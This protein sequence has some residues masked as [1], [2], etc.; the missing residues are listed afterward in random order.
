MQYSKTCI[1][2][3]DTCVDKNNAKNIL[4]NDSI[5]NIFKNFDDK[6][7]SSIEK[8]KSN[9]SKSLKDGKNYIKKIIKIINYD[10]NIYDKM[11]YK[12][13]LQLSG[14]DIISS[15]YD[16]LR[17]KILEIKD[18]SKRQLYIIKFTKFFTR[19]AYDSENKFW[20]YC[21]KTGNKLLPNF[22]VKLA[23]V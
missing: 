6:Y 3:N 19:T 8:I 15:P 17:D 1:N 7:E 12:I 23:E 18:F 9:L 10:K 16:N 2:I 20:L 5:N 22:I 11:F 14:S 13:G 21:I 4:N